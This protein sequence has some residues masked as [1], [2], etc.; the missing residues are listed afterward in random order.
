MA[1]VR[2]R[3]WESARQLEINVSES[4]GNEVPDA[5][6]G[7]KVPATEVVSRSRRRTYTAAYKRQMVEQADAMTVQERGALLRREGLYASHLTSWRAEL[8]RAGTIKDKKRGP[9]A[10]P[11]RQ[12]IKQLEQKTA[13]L[14]AKLKQAELIIGAQKK[15]A[16]LLGTILPTEEEILGHPR[17]R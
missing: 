2:W 15:L 11:A 12:R 16:D 1:S 10:D 14:E 4:D 17:D 13:R 3:R 7:E 6:V 5:G 9:K 8:G